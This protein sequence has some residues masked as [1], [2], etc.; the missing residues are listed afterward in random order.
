MA[1]CSATV[2]LADINPSSGEAAL[3]ELRS[4]QKTSS[5]QVKPGVKNDPKF[6]SEKPEAHFI[7]VDVSKW[8]SVSNMFRMAEELLLL[9]GPGTRK[10]SEER[11]GKRSI[12]IVLA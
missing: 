12:D 11:P 9:G 3:K 2:I 1:L 7:Q 4:T 6:D 8:S 5:L 10:D